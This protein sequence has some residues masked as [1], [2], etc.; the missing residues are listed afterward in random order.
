MWVSQDYTR[1]APG[2][3]GAAKCG[4]NYA[5]SLAAQS[6]AI[7]EGC[8]QV[9]YLDAVER[10]YVEELG[11]MNVF[12]VFEDGSIRTPPLGGS[13]LVYCDLHPR[14]SVHIAL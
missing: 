10:R 8:D 3:T 2:G 4:G 14:P 7:R 5:A 9:V 6:Q 11:G 12:F 13:A 1:A